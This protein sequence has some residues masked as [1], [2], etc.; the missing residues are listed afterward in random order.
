MHLTRRSGIL[1]SASLLLMGSTG[2]AQADVKLPKVFASHMVLQRDMSLPVW[3]WAAPN[4]SVTV[5]LAS[6]QA[7]TK[8]NASGEWKVTLPAQKAGGPFTLT[9]KGSNT[10]QCDDVLIGEV[11]LCSGQSN[12]EMGIGMVNNAQ[13][14]I[15]AADFPKIRLL[16]VPNRF[17]A[18]PQKDMEGEWKVCTPKSVSEGGWNGFSAA[19]YFFGRQLHK[20]LGVPIGLIDSTWGGTVIQTWTPPVGF[21]SVPALKG[22]YDRVLLADPATSSHKARLNQTI[23]ETERWLAQARKSVADGTV[24]PAMPTFP[25]ELLPPHDVQNSTALYNGMIHP[26]VPF[27]IRGAIWY[28]GEANLGEGRM[29]TERM[30]ALVGGWRQI[31]HEPN[32]PFYF[33]QVAPYNYGGNPQVEAEFWEAQAAAQIIPGSGMVVTNDIGN[34][35]DI[36]PKDKQEVGRRLALWAMAKTYGKSDLVCAGPTVRSAKAEGSKYRITFDNTAGGLKSRDGKPLS[37][38]EVIDADEGGFVKA[39][40]QID[41]NS[42]VLSAPGVKNPVAV[43]YAWSMFAEPNLANSEGLPASAFRVGEAPKRDLITINVPEAKG[44]QL[45]YDLDPVKFSQTGK[46]DVD[47]SGSIKAPFDRI[48]YALELQ[49]QTGE[50]QFAYASMDAFTSDIKKIGVPTFASGARFQQNV[51]NLNVFSNVKSVVTGTGLQGGNIEFW[52]DNYATANAAKVPNASNDTF[53]F[54]D[55]PGDPRDGY[56]CMQVHNHDARQTIFAFNNFKVGSGADLGIGNRPT[57]GPDWT[58][59]GN[60]G[61]F[62]TRRLRVYVH[63]K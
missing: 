19:G 57:D 37:W 49:L 14:E 35:Q 29:Y 27:A 46:Y 47:N 24:A 7:N 2:V 52:S 44:Y 41:G 1:L 16:M 54:G 10:V 39:D 30:K 8:A 38:F 21:A 28:Q 31:W 9:V 58:F 5:K 4:E 56:G 33:V 63:M 45:V 6:A 18:E 17:M 23:E 59:A 40:A 3:G 13:A 26:L 51:A 22:D 42:V 61:S 60:A 50:T 43:R 12:M 55:E 20:Q 36:H 15:A 11:W 32:M 34:I 62:V 53:D 25:A 48:A